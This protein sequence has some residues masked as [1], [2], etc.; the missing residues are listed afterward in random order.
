VKRGFG[1]RNV[2]LG[3]IVLR[4]RLRYSR[5]GLHQ[6]GVGG[7][8]GILA[9]IEVRL[10]DQPVFVQTLGPFPNPAYCGRSR[11][12]RAAISACEVFERGVGGNPNPSGHLQ[13]GFVG[14]DV[15]RRLDVFPVAPAFA[16]SSR[17]HPLSQ[18][19]E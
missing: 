15:R 2:A 16:L 19:D 3:G 9:A 12:G 13:R 14:V 17:D 5:L 1:L 8:P 6:A 10:R 7:G 18:K 11:P 4:L